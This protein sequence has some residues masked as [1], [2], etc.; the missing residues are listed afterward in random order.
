MIIKSFCNT[1]ETNGHG[2]SVCICVCVCWEGGEGGGTWFRL[3][4]LPK[5]REAITG[6]E[7]S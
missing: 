1:C 7:L 5:Q 4:L 3:S 2:Q 6:P